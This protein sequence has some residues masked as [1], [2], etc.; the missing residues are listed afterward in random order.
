VSQSVI[1]VMKPKLPKLDLV[2][3]L[4][5]QMD[6]NRIYTNQGPILERA[7]EE[8]AIFLGVKAQNLVFCSNA[9]QGLIAL[10]CVSDVAGYFVPDYSFLASPLAVL[11]ANKKLEL[12]DVD[13]DFRIDLNKQSKNNGFGL[14]D[15]LPF[16]DNNLKIDNYKLYEDVIIDGAAS[17]ANFINKLENLPEN[18]SIVFSLHATKIMGI[19]EGGLIYSKDIK[20][21]EKIRKYINFGFGEFRNPEIPG[22]NG[23]LG[24]IAGCY[25]IAAIND[26]QTEKEEWNRV[27][28]LIIERQNNLDLQDL[29]ITN[30]GINPYWIIDTSNLENLNVII[31][32]LSENGIETRKWWQSFHNI[33]FLKP[34]LNEFGYNNSQNFFETHLGLPKF[35]DMHEKEIDAI[36]NCLDRY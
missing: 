4:I 29:T 34:Y 17:L 12:C 25:V 7:K 16:G 32:D 24:E 5:K 14:L 23:K 28:K 8:M 13:N 20:K 33:N 19:G 22:T 3:D 27:N 10:A 18:V 36:F 6:Q 9:T 21:V 11:N 1:P 35:R 2:S 26:W 15:V 30:R 31:S